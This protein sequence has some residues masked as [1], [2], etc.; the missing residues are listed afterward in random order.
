MTII[1]DF[2]VVYLQP[3]ILI[4]KKKKKTSSLTTLL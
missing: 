1:F 3:N 2:Y 4:W